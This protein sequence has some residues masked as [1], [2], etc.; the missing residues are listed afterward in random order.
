MNEVV[1]Q[2]TE[3]LSADQILISS[4]AILADN[5][6]YLIE[7]NWQDALNHHIRVRQV[8][9]VKKDK[10]YAI[11]YMAP[12]KEFDKFLPIVEEVMLKSLQVDSRSEF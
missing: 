11:I 9:M 3:P 7:Y 8:L 6:A 4:P 12:K 1:A 10:V 2:V 5:E